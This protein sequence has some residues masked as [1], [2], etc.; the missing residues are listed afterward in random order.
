MLER[1]YHDKAWAE[2]NAFEREYRELLYDAYVHGETTLLQR[3]EHPFFAHCAVC[4]LRIDT[5]DTMVMITWDASPLWSR[6]YVYTHETCYR[7]E[8]PTREPK[9]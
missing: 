3:G 1:K 8:V 5:R 6:G 4:S 9:R 2:L 7:K